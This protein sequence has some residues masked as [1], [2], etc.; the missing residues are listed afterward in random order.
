MRVKTNQIYQGIGFKY[1]ET[2]KIIE[3]AFCDSCGLV[4]GRDK[5][6][7]STRCSKCR[8]KMK[9]Y[10]EGIEGGEIE[11]MFSIPT[12]EY[13]QSK[14]YWHCPKCKKETLELEFIGC[15]D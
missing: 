4:S 12:D 1:F 13:L 3:P 2:G 15:W 5:N 8:K 7:I 9:F 11:R 6:K 14:K 10:K